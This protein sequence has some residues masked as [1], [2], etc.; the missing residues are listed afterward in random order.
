VILQNPDDPDDPYYNRV[1]AAEYLN[2]EPGTL[3][4]WDCTKRYDLKPVR[5]HGKVYYLL[6][7]LKQHM[8]RQLIPV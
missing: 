4:V 3:A 2:K 7:V 8:S 6:S 1:A 5:Y